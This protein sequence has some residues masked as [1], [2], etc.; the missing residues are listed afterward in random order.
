MLGRFEYKRGI[1]MSFCLLSLVFRKRMVLCLTRC[2]F[3]PPFTEGRESRVAGNGTEWEVKTIELSQPTRIGEQPAFL[4]FQDFTCFWIY[5]KWCSVKWRLRLPNTLRLNLYLAKCTVHGSHVLRLVFRL[6][7]KIPA[8]AYFCSSS[9]PPLL[10]P[11]RWCCAVHVW[12]Y[13]RA[14]SLFLVKN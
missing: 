7:S 13:I 14:N 6:S 12:T 11:W 4:Y 9:L 3:Q 8:V 5:G 10:A 2:H 1:E